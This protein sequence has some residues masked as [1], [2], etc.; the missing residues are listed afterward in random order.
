MLC[1]CTCT[2]EVICWIQWSIDD[3]YVMIR[4]S[5]WP[6]FVYYEL[7]L[8]RKHAWFI[9]TS[10]LSQKPDLSLREPAVAA[11]QSRATTYFA[12]YWGYSACKESFYI[13]LHCSPPVLSRQS[14]YSLVVPNFDRE[15]RRLSLASTSGFST[16]R[17]GRWGRDNTSKICQNQNYC[18]YAGKSLVALIINRILYRHR[19]TIETANLPL[20]WP[21]RDRTCPIPAKKSPNFGLSKCT[22]QYSTGNL[23]YSTYC[24]VL[25]Q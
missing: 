23:W 20:F 15:F 5:K 13:T 24:T 3:H 9:F 4:L 6:D 16:F 17:C 19:F 2:E 11:K 7:S 10:C 8:R 12:D 18:V 21:R 1:S 22:V 25:V 14:D